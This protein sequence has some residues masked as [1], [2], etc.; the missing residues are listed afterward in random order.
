MAQYGVTR[1]LGS[2]SDPFQPSLIP[3]NVG[4]IA[5]GYLAGV[6]LVKAGRSR[7]TK[8][9]V[10][11]GSDDAYGV[12]L[13]HVMVLTALV[14]LGWQHLTSVIPWPL[15]CVLTVALIFAVCVPF[16]ELVA[17]TPLAMPLVGRKRVPLP[18]WVTTP[19]FGMKNMNKRNGGGLHE[20]LDEAAGVAAGVPEG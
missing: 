3:F 7:F 5:C 17:R 19:P 20:A 12:Y 11:A 9:V 10:R 6:A 8:A 2:T 1:A 14:W 4:A 18:R 16:T 13:S 15:L